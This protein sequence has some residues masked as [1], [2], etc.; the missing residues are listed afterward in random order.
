MAM[1]I[2]DSHLIG[3]IQCQ[4]GALKSEFSIYKDLNESIKMRI[5]YLIIR[6]IV[7]D[8]KE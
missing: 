3:H 8:L 2:L 1:S 4:V 7:I 6:I 5:T